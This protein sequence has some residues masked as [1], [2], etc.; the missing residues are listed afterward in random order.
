[1]ALKK[2]LA[3]GLGGEEGLCQPGAPSAVAKGGNPG[4]RPRQGRRGSAPRG[5]AGARAQVASPP[6]CPPVKAGTGSGWKGKRLEVAWVRK[7]V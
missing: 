7:A 6:R 2:P 4:A 5:G 3:P 1:M